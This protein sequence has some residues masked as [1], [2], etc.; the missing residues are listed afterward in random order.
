MDVASHV[1]RRALKLIKPCM[2]EG[3]GDQ[4]EQR[5]FQILMYVGSWLGEHLAQADKL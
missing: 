1:H 5:L 4:A 3:Y 2:N